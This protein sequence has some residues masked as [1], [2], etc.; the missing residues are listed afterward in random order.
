M[1]EARTIILNPAPVN[2][3]KK[4]SGSQKKIK[5][6]IPGSIGRLIDKLNQYNE[7]YDIWEMNIE[8]I[9]KLLPKEFDELKV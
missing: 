9:I 6:L 3:Q 7:I 1:I 5:K 2:V 8:D 4:I